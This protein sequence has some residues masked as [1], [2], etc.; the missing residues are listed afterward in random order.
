MWPSERAGA[1]KIAICVYRKKK[2][3]TVKAEN[4]CRSKLIDTSATRIS[5]HERGSSS[6][7]IF[8]HVQEADIKNI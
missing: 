8:E 1:V 5:M 2:T 3:K 4:L 6:D 7:Y